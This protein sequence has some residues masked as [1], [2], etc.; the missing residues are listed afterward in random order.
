VKAKH[1][2]PGMTVRWTRRG[3]V[4]TT[5]VQQMQFLNRGRMYIGGP[6][7]VKGETGVWQGAFLRRRQKVKRVR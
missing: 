5:H 4:I 1:V 6:T 3:H 2:W 7:T